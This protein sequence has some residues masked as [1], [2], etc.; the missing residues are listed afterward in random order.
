MSQEFKNRTLT[1]VI[2]LL[3]MTAMFFS[4]FVFVFFLIIFLTISIVE[5]LN[6]TN[7]IHKNYFIKIISNFLF[8][9]YVFII[10]NI[11]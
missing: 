10:F 11:I 6:I 1:S 7:I 9:S 3:S 2:L 8:I 5:F 4:N